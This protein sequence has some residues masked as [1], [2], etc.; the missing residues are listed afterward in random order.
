MNKAKAL[1]KK[2]GL[3]EKLAIYGDRKSFLKAIAQVP[4]LDVSETAAYLNYLQRLSG[5]PVTHIDSTN[6]DSVLSQLRHND[7]KDPSKKSLFDTNL[8]LAENALAKAHANI[9]ANLAGHIPPE[10]NVIDID[11]QPY[12]PGDYARPGDTGDS[13]MSASEYDKAKREYA[14]KV[15][16][17]VPRDIQEKL[18]LSGAQLT[19]VMDKETKRRLDAFKLYHKL[20]ASTQ[21][22]QVFSKIRSQSN[23]EDIYEDDGTFGQ[24]H[25]LEKVKRDTRYAPMANPLTSSRKM[26]EI[27]K[28]YAQTVDLELDPSDYDNIPPRLQPKKYPPIPTDIQSILGFTGA[29]IDGKL[30][31]ATEAKLK[32]FKNYFKLNET[33]DALYDKI[34]MIS[35]TTVASGQLPNYKPNQP[36]DKS[37]QMLLSVPQTGIKDQ[38]TSKA[39]YN[40]KLIYMKNPGATDNDAIQFMQQFGEMRRLNP[41]ITPEQVLQA[42]TGNLGQQS[43]NNQL[44]TNQPTTIKSSASVDESNAKFATKFASKTT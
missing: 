7:A 23:S 20:P 25:D 34:R 18:G 38:A 36:I 3:F 2:V 40:I 12:A 41:N 37:I 9:T 15:P 22:N 27:L 8:Q 21:L 30:G 16:M 4:Q 33:G 19:G 17:S 42:L 6:V 31:P 44:A 10:E 32:E 28:K 11:N 43:T 13:G 5:L 29:Q 39:L 14:G 24:Y 35:E 1:L 26:K